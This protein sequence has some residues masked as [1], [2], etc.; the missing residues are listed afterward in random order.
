MKGQ[1]TK[2]RK[3]ERGCSALV[4]VQSEITLERNKAMVGEKVEVLV[5][6]RDQKDPDVWRG[7]RGPTRWCCE[8]DPGSSLLG[9]LVEVEVREAGLWYLK[10]Q[11]QARISQL[12]G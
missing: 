12:G 7:A 3:V 11:S 1:D 6:E 4:D 10:G 5:E 2:E 9:C 8:G